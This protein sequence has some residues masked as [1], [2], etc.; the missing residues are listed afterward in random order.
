VR[1]DP[2]AI[3]QGDLLMEIDFLAPRMEI[4]PIGGIVLKTM[5]GNPIWGT[6][7]RFHPSQPQGAQ[8]S[9][10]TLKCEARNLPLASDLYLASVWLSDWNTN[11]D[12]R[13]DPI[14]IQLGSRRGIESLRPSNNA[15]GHLDWPAVWTFRAK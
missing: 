8:A 15:I 6:N 4:S 9:S 1:V 13:L 5:Q 12:N 7:G 10:G 14:K 11:Y 3:K 2:Q